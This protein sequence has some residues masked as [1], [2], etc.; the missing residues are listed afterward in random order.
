VNEE[1]NRWHAYQTVTTTNSESRPLQAKVTSSGHSKED[2]TEIVADGVQKG[3]LKADALS[4]K[5]RQAEI[6]AI[7]EEMLLQQGHKAVGVARIHNRDANDSEI[8]K[9]S[10]RISNDHNKRKKKPK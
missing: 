9:K 5:S 10:Q 8:R 1:L 7:Q 4:Q 6:R 3:L 2:L